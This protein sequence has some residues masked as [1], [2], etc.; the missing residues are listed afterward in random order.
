MK[1]CRV[2][3]LLVIIILLAGHF[4]CTSKNVTG[5]VSRNGMVV[6]VD[7]YATRVGIDILKKGGN[8]VDAAVAV[9]FALAVTFPAAGNIG[10]G[11]FLVCRL[12]ADGEV[13]ALDFREKAP[14]RASADMYLDES[15]TYVE[16]RS[17]V[18]HLAVGVPGT[19]KGFELA[20]Q[21]YGRL[22]WSEVIAPAIKLAEEGFSLSAGRADSFNALAKR[23]KN[24]SPEFLRIFSKTDCSEFS[25]GDLF[26]QPELGRSLRLISEKGAAAFYAGEIADLIVRDM[27]KHNGLITHADL[28]KY[29]VYLRRPVT[30]TYRGYQVYS[31]PPPSSGGTILIEMLNILE[32]FDLGAQERFAPETL[33]LIA[34]AMKFAYYDRACY[35][36]DPDFGDIPSDRLLS[37]E[38]AATIRAQIDPKRAVPSRELGAKILT[39]EEA[40][41][42]THYSVIDKDGMAV[43]VT[44]TLNGGFGAGVVAEGTGILLNNEMADFNMKPGFTGENGLIG[45]KPNLIAPHKKMLSSMTPTLVVKDNRI[46]MITGSPGGRTIINTVLNVLLNV[47]DFKMDI[48]AAVATARM[49]HEWMPDIIRL[50]K[51]V[52]TESLAAAL[53]AMGHK[54]KKGWRQGDAH[55]IFIDEQGRYWGAAD[56]RS[57]GSAVGY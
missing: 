27:E 25:A 41:E 57:Q 35:L 37:K 38:Y 31:M 7:E 28:E 43:A 32:G 49:D 16:E 5:P 20:V 21:D 52:F 30:G 48:H 40:P 56:P 23:F 13:V 55:S 22:S 11:G 45:T 18:G 53:E 1:K 29:Q 6:S 47:I 4:Q 2:F 26:L 14:G 9:G 17:L 36:G 46:V 15:G 39:Q 50:E 3:Y 42:T 10:G 34:E 12:P 51:D 44:Y 8:A 54:V 24:G 33:H 19:V